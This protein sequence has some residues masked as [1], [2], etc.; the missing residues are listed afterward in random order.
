MRDR[1]QPPSVPPL[2][3]EDEDLLKDFLARD[4]EKLSDKLRT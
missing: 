2:S 3:S 1:I 4:D